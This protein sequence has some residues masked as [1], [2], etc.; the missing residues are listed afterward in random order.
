MHSIMEAIQGLQTIVNAMDQWHV[1]FENR[2]Y[3]EFNRI[4]YDHLFH[5]FQGNQGGAADPMSQDP[6]GEAN[7]TAWLLFSFS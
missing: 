3:D 7:S 5:A 6:M 1:E 4:H 2:V